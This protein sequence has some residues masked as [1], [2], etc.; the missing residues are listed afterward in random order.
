MMGTF[1]L[2]VPMQ[3]SYIFCIVFLASDH[4]YGESSQFAVIVRSMNIRCANP[5]IILLVVTW[6]DDISSDPRKIPL[7]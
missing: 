5:I 4:N 3:T 2:E 6:V 7:T 1:L